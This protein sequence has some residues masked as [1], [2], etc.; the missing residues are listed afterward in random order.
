MPPQVQTLDVAG[1]STGGAR[2]TGAAAPGARTPPSCC[3]PQTT[4]RPFSVVGVTWPTEQAVQ[5]VQVRVRENGT[6]S[7]VDDAAAGRRGPG[8][9]HRPSTRRRRPAPAPPRSTTDGAD[10]VQ[11]RVDTPTGTAPHGRAGQP[12]RPRHLG[13]RRRP[14]PARPS[15]PARPTPRSPRRGSSAARSGGPTRAWRRRP[16]EHH[17]QGP[18]A[19]PHRR[20]QQLHPGPGGGPAARRV[21]LPHAVAGLVRHRLQP[22]GRP[23]RDDLRG[24]PRQRHQRTAAAR[25]RAAST[26][27][28]TGSR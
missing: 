10:G 16:R 26:A 6:W 3:P 20:L 18:G 8:R 1:V 11:V 23:L 4:T 24:P 9:R 2:T 12:D 21:R 19:A 28:P 7:A 25:T 13:R 5:R 14:R 17:G 22:R 27:T 15:R